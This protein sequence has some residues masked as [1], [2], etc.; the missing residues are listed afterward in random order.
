MAMLSS[1][2]AS[3]EELE[4]RDALDEIARQFHRDLRVF[5]I[6]ASASVKPAT[7]PRAGGAL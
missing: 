7:T 3:H 5:A 6:F 2:D 4:D 1:H